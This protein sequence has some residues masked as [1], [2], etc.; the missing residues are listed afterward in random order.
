MAGARSMSPRE[1]MKSVAACESRQ[2]PCTADNAPS[3]KGHLPKLLSLPRG[4]RPEVWDAI[5]GTISGWPRRGLLADWT[6]P[7]GLDR[8][9]LGAL[10]GPR[11]GGKPTTRYVIYAGRDASSKARGPP[12]HKSRGTTS[13]HRSPTL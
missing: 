6:L 8:A 2:L 5:Y 13:Q 10:A 7:F 12:A 4:C 11:R 3:C 1:G 9:I